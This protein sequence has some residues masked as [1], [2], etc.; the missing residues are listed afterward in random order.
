MFLVGAK[1]IKELRRVP[2]VITGK[3]K[4]WAEARKIDIKKFANR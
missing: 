2:I 4:D 3:T 1:N